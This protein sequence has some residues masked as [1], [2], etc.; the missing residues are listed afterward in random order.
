[1]YPSH[2]IEVRQIKAKY[3]SLSVMNVAS[4]NDFIFHGY[5]KPGVS[6]LSFFLSQNI[7]HGSKEHSFLRVFEN[8]KQL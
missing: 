2:G 1:V 8:Y 5:T 6:T 4:G 3:H 7:F